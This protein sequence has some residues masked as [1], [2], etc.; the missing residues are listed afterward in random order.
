MSLP[1]PASLDD[2]TPEWL[3]DALGERVSAVE[4][5]PVGVGVGILALLARLRLTYGSVEC[6]LPSTMVGKIASSNPET[7]GISV[8]Y[9]FYVNEVQFYRECSLTPGLRTPAVY[10]GDIDSTGSAFVLLLED[11]GSARMADQVAGCP[12][13]DAAHV[14]DAAAAL[15]S[16]WWDSPK[17]HE[18][19]WLR[20]VNNDAYKSAQEQYL[21]VWPGFV[22]RFATRVPPGGLAVA[23]AFGKKIA[24]HFDWL[25]AN[26]PT[27]IAHT[28]F[29]LDNFFFEHADGS[30]VTIIDWQLSVRNVGA[31]DVSYFLGES[32]SVDDRR[33]HERALLE[34]YHEG[35]VA[36][37]VTG[38]S[39]NDLYD[40]YRMS[41]V[42]QLTVPVIGSSM[43]PGNE[44]GVQLFD[45][46]VERI[47]TAIDD[48]DAGRFM[49]V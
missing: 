44:R 3:S 11:L 9:G 42:T 35:L 31:I 13:A 26:R 28:D 30:P 24:D 37:G 10:H 49:P 22:D 40:D 39:F 14:I 41:L 36:G 21:A 25:I 43:D 19:S 45:A 16:Y 32:L 8:H 34:R 33:E 29:R 15:H 18:L 27:T 47:L 48:H 1:I 23:E 46:A 6:E 2:F 12:P 38:Y 4:I 20:P 5:E 17:L 7:V